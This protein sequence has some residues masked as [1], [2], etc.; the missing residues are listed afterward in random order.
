MS[1]PVR[2]LEDGTRV[3]ANGVKYKPVAADERRNKVRRPEDPR[4]VRWYSEW[5]ILPELAP[6]NFRHMPETVPDSEAFEHWLKK[7]G[8]RCSI[9]TR[10]ESRRWKEKAERVREQGTRPE[11][12]SDRD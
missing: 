8:C 11:Q 4:A 1:G 12:L 10:P 3:Y 9:C 2:V 6:E 7:R 5:L